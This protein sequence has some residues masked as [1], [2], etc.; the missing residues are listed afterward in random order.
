MRTRIESSELS[1]KNYSPPSCETDACGG[2][3][4]AAELGEFERWIAA[5]LVRLEDQFRSFRTAHSLAGTWG[6]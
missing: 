4:S 2:S 6:R 1:I 5:D 3:A